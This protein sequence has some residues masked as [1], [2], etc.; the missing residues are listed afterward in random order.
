LETFRDVGIIHIVVLSGYNMTI[1]L[2]G[3]LYTLSRFR[4]R[5]ALTIAAIL[6]IAFAIFVGL[7]ATVL[8]ASIMALLAIL[9]RLLGRPII[10]MRT[11]FIAAGAMLLWNPLVLL[12]DPSFQLSFIAT[13]GLIAASPI[14]ERNIKFLSRINK[15][16]PNWK[17]IVKEIITA[18]T[19]TQIFVLPA[20]IYMTGKFSAVSMPVNLLVLPLVPWAM[21][22]TG[23]A[24]VAG[25]FSAALSK[26][27]ALPAYFILE[28]IIKVSELSSKLPLATITVKS[29]PL[30]LVF[31][32]YLIYLRLIWEPPKSAEPLAKI[33]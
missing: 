28:F 2:A 14:I 24:G 1:I 6:T 20:L 27:L 16:S 25:F 8:R 7:S 31:V 21:A 19:A 17:Q 12:Y 9:A 23:I 11:L 3:V 13:F 15:N 18:T 33:V 32:A 5:A 4:R 26:V 29:I 30:W 10:A 22:F